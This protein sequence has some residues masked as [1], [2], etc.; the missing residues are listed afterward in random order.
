MVAVPQW[1]SSRGSGYGPI[2]G[3]VWGI[4]I[5]DNVHINTNSYTDIGNSYMYSVPSGVQDTS[6]ILAGT[7]KFTPD[8]VEMFYIR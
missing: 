4:C 1:A 8:E 5:A 2:F 7:Q 6:T 3:K